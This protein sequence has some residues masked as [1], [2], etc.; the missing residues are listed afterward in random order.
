[1]KIDY[2]IAIVGA[3]PAGCACALALHNTGVKVALIDKDTYPRDKICGDAIPGPAFKAIDSLDKNWLRQMRGIQ[4]KM[5]ITTTAAYLSESKSFRYDWIL[6]SYNSK[7]IHFDNFLFQL[8]KNETDTI[9]LENKKLQKITSEPNYKLLKFQDGSSFS[10]SM[11]IGCDGANSIVKREFV[12]DS[13]KNNSLIAVRAYYKNINGIQPG[14]NECYFIKG[15]DG[16][17][18]IF[19]LNDNWVNVGLGL[20]NKQKNKKPIDI[21]AIFEKILKAP[22]FV[23]RFKNAERIGDIN[24]FGLPIYTNR[25]ALSGHRFLLCG[26]A[27]SL[28]DPLQG[29]GIDKAMWSGIMA[30]KQAT[31]CF[32]DNNFSADFMKQYDAQLYKRFGR[33]LASKY[34]LMRFFLKFPFLLR[35]L[36]HLNFN[37]N[38]TKWIIR[39]LKI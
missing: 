3:G 6:Y 31:S 9:T 36:F 13:R 11:I 20:L 22:S 10:A 12:K 29:H 34:F 25:K 38:L 18:W 1:M 27:A 2:D 35:F 24:G 39:K 32:E 26:D 5:D 33:E 17:F 21:R 37:E 14:V 30:A 4:N 7:R 28:V 19:P 23:D 8:V 15:I 16:Y